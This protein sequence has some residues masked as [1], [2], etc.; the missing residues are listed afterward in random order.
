MLIKKTALWIYFVFARGEKLVFSVK[1]GKN[2]GENQSKTHIVSWKVGKN[3]IFLF[4]YFQGL[5]VISRGKNHRN[6]VS[7]AHIRAFIERRVFLLS[8]GKN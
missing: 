4:F 8:A 1:I 2:F 5:S 7:K 6:F 3:K